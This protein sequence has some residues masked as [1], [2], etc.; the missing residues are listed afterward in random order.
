MATDRRSFLFAATAGL[1]TFGSRLYAAESSSDAVAALQKFLVRI[2]SAP[3]LERAAIARAVLDSLKPLAPPTVLVEVAAIGALVRRTT[4]AQS[5][6]EKYP[7]RSRLA[8]DAAK[9]LSGNAGWAHALDGAWHYEVV[10]RS[11]LGAILYGASISDG[12]ALFLKAA[13]LEPSDPGIHLA[14]AAALLGSNAGG[15]AVRAR[16]ILADA[17]VGAV[18]PYSEMMAKQAQTLVALLQAGQSDEAARQAAKLF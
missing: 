8:L 5:I 11:K 15:N 13:T 3:E 12:E 6:R 4:S 9:R 17:P 1:F 18:T 14:H 10:R 7:S 2:G 16:S